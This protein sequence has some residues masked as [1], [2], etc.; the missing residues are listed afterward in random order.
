MTILL[1]LAATFYE[2]VLLM[3]KSWTYQGFQVTEA[4]TTPLLNGAG[5]STEETHTQGHPQTSE[6]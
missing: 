2:C 5:K 3:R 4:E 6:T 1:C